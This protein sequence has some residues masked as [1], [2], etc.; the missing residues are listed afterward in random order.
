MLNPTI[1]PLSDGDK[2]LITLLVESTAGDTLVS[3]ERRRRFE[4][5]EVVRGSENVTMLEDAI[6][7]AD[8]EAG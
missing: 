7:V 8:Y 3:V 4:F 5:V 6:F 1:A 2:H